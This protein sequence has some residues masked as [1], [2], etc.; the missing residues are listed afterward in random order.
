MR[1]CTIQEKVKLGSILDKKCG[2]GQISHI[3]LEGTFQQRRTGM[4]YA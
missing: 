1:T 2:G 3:N 4:G